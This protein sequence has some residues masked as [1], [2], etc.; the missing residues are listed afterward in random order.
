M[1]ELLGAGLNFLGNMGSNNANKAMAEQNL[2]F[3]RDA[4]RNGIKWKVEDAREAGI[5]P[6]A[7]LGAQTF[8]PTPVSLNSTWD[9]SVGTGIA[10]AGAD[11]SSS[12]TKTRTPQQK[13]DAFTKTTQDLQLTR[14]GLENELLASQI[15]KNMPTGISPPGPNANPRT[16]VDGQTATSITSANGTPVG[17]D[18]LKQQLDTMPASQMARPVGV[19]LRTN[20]YT[21]DAQDMED[22]Y[23][24]IVE[25]ITGI[26]NLGADALYTMYKWIEQNKPQL[27]NRYYYTN[28][29]VYNNYSRY[30]GRTR[31]PR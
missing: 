18:P 31:G 30:S 9:S 6:L 1:F 5:A 29:D 28:R 23:G 25:E 19:P 10:K 7:A 11:I 3:Q 12:L 17:V 14:M 2:N 24:D 15:R 27:L 4:A 22:R 13:M 20:K 8:N 16:L 26:G 21:S